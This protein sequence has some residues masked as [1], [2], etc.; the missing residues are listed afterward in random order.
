MTL[1]ALVSGALEGLVAEVIVVDGG[2]TDK[3]LEI[4][5]EAGCNIVHSVKGRGQ[6]LAKGAEEARG[7]W[8]LFL[9]A[10]T[11]LSDNWVEETFRFMQRHGAEKAGYCRFKLDAEG[12][13]P[14]LL[15]KLVALRCTLFALPYGD[16]ALLLNRQLYDA[17]GGYASLPLMEDVKLVRALGRRRLVALPI[18]ALTSPARFEKA[19][20][21]RR[22][23]KNITC[24]LLYFLKVPPSRIAKVY[25]R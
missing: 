21:L 17:V 1:A 19:G 24:L 16:Q 2:S 4:A 18:A 8:L 12:V 5:D 13:R 14:R 15:E 25:G 3:T 9:H 10:D 23:L 11:V 6:Q 22:S 7:Q 20:Y